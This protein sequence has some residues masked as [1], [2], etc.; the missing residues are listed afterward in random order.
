MSILRFI[1]LMTIKSLARIFYRF[2]IT[3]VTPFP[4]SAWNEIRLGILLNHTSLIEPIFSGAFSNRYLWNIAA[5]GVFPVADAT[6]KAPVIGFMIRLLAPK[7]IPLSRRRDDTWTRFLKELNAKDT[8]I[9]MPEGRMKRANGLDKN[10]QPMTV[11]SGIVDVLEIFKTGTML[12]CYS[13]GLHHIQLPGSGFPKLF[14]T[15]R[16]TFELISIESYLER[17]RDQ[18][19]PRSAI[20]ADLERRR[21]LYAHV[22]QPY[23]DRDDRQILPNQKIR[24]D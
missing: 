24:M 14:K 7:V 1:V 3:Y 10:G 18:V 19:D 15:V 8:L 23:C 13:E 17:F 22:G 20:I 11:K 6:L 21:D 9:F 16:G 4:K 2:D 5:K 12:L